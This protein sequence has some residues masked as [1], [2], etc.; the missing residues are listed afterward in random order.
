MKRMVM[1]VILMIQYGFCVSGQQWPQDFVLVKGGNYDREVVGGIGKGKAKIKDFYI[2]KYELTVSEWKA[3]LK[4]IGQ[5]NLFEEI[6]VDDHEFIPISKVTKTDDAPMPAINFIE[7]IQYCNWRSLQEGLQEVYTITGKVPP[8]Q[9]KYS[10]KY[11]MPN[12]TYNTTANGYRLPTAMEWEWAAL[13]GAEGIKSR[14]WEKIYL[15]DYEYS[16]ADYWD[17]YNF[18]VKSKKPNPLG[19]YHV[20]S[21]VYERCWDE[22]IYYD[23]IKRT[24]RIIKGV[25]MFELGGNEKSFDPILIRDGYQDPL[26]RNSTGIRLVRN[27]E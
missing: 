12:I 19:L 22:G 2:S 25:R 10:S 4:A 14:W 7:A 8:F 3:Y 13:G 6:S 23:D 17:G 11:Q 15:L 1:A 16:R 20:F 27:A 24:S 9:A 26:S 21:N 18:P 5:I